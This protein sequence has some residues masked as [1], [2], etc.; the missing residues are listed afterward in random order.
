MRS[1]TSALFARK[2]R[3]GVR[4]RCEAWRDTPPATRP[5]WGD[6][7]SRGFGGARERNGGLFAFPSAAR[8]CVATCGSGGEELWGL[9][10]GTLWGCGMRKGL[11]FVVDVG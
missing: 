2:Q 11:H 5:L 6:M 9:L 1:K 4:L 8:N 3:A 7:G 10:W